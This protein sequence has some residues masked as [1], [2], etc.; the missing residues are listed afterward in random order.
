MKK[1]IILSIVTVSAIIFTGCA[2]EQAAINQGISTFATDV[3]KVAQAVVTVGTT[4]VTVGTD[5]LKITG[6]IA[7]DATNAVSVVVTNTANIPQ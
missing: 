6:A 5:T 2:S 7:T 4:A 1:L 3:N